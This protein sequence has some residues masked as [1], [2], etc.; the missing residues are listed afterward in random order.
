MESEKAS[1]ANQDPYSQWSGTRTTNDLRP[2]CS[3][4]TLGN[5]TLKTDG[6]VKSTA[7]MSGMRQMVAS[8]STIN[9]THTVTRQYFTHESPL[10]E[11]AKFNGQVEKCADIYHSV[12]LQV[13]TIFEFFDYQIV[14]K[15]M[16][17]LKL[18][19]AVELGLLFSASEFDKANVRSRKAAQSPSSRCRDRR[20]NRIWESQAMSASRYLAFSSHNLSLKLAL[21]S[22]GWT[23]VARERLKEHNADLPDFYAVNLNRPLSFSSL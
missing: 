7:S 11:E 8:A 23:M 5:L 16:M 1:R 14:G 13:L 9:M 22:V 4:R 20:W 17:L 21:A 10:W 6:A 15:V 12:L 19:G 3:H 18:V 2:P